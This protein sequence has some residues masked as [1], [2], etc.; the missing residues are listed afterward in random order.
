[1]NTRQR[2]SNSFIKPYIQLFGKKFTS[3]WQI[4]RHGIRAMNSE[5]PW[6]RRFNEALSP[7]SSSSLLKLSD[8]LSTNWYSFHFLGITNISDLLVSQTKFG[9]FNMILGPYCLSS[10]WCHWLWTYRLIITIAVCF[11]A[12]VLVLTKQKQAFFCGFWG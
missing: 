4:E 5:T 11:I 1:M 10:P 6:I 8:K 3:V 9:K 7:P 12:L 2:F